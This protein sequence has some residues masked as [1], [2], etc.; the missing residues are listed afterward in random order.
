MQT[1]IVQPPDA[2]GTPELFYLQPG[3]SLRFGRGTAD[4][5]PELVL[6]HA[7]VSRIAGEIRATEN[8]WTL[9]NFSRTATLVVE[10]PEGAGEF[11]KVPP[12]RDGSPI[13]FEIARVVIPAGR[14][15]VSFQVYAPMHSY[16]DGGPGDTAVGSRT[17]TAFALDGSAKYFLVLVALCE[18]RLRDQSHVVI[19]TAEQVVERLKPL[20]SC[21]DLTVGAV[22]FHVDYLARTKLRVKL[23]HPDGR[24]E[25]LEARREALVSLALRFNLVSEEHLALL[26]PSTRRSPA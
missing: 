8:F 14:E 23:P 20:P 12:L 2:D 25:R 24:S 5:R 6:E 4:V 16:L 19:P 15:L 18:P 7:G 22:G 1:V 13:P 17:T 21:A 9:T 26:P 10:N 3:Q 11:V